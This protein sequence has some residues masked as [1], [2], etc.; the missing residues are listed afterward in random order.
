ME[1]ST[2]LK[3][4]KIDQLISDCIKN[5]NE[6]KSTRVGLFEEMIKLGFIS[7]DDAIPIIVKE[8]RETVDLGLIVI[9]MKYEVDKN[10]Y[11]NVP[12]LGP[13]HIL[14]YAYQQHYSMNKHLFE[15]FYILTV[16][17]GTST[18]S[19]SYHVVQ[20]QNPLEF[21]TGIKE[22]HIQ[23]ESVYEWLANKGCKIPSIASE[24][25]EYVKLLPKYDQNVINVYTNSGNE[26]PPEM[27]VYML[28]SRNPYWKKLKL[29]ELKPNYLK[30]AVNS[31][32]F[33]LV[34]NML[35]TGLRP[36]YIDFSFWIAHYKYISNFHN[37]NYLIE[38]CELMI[39][40]LI[41][42][43][44]K[45]DLYYLDEIGSINPRFRTQLI[46]EYQRP[47]FKKV[48]SNNEDGYIPDEIKTVAVY[49]GIS[50]S[51]KANFCSSIE[52]ITSADLDSLIGA[53]QKKNNEAMISKVNSLADYINSTHFKG[54]TNRGDFSDNPLNYPIDLLA[55]YKDMEG[56][57]WCFLSKDF[58]SL[59][60]KKINPTTKLSLPED[61]II[62]LDVQTKTLKFFGINL[63]DP[64]TISKIIAEIKKDDSPS[65]SSSDIVIE[66]V[67]GLLNSKGLTEHVLIYD[68]PLRDI[69]NRFKRL[70]VDF[71]DIILL[72]D[73]EIDKT[74]DQANTE[75]SPK[76]I[77]NLLC[78]CLD[79]EL[80][81]DFNQL[82]AFFT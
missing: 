65:N 70:G 29:E 42:R 82:T 24:L 3:L 46:E 45:I 47:L 55:Y 60:H 33:E 17:L 59:L 9:C 66:R 35:N 54:C 50:D 39:I 57:T 13:A 19:P 32:F 37:N 74:I 43:G 11:V 79:A 48:C 71:Q 22:K 23:V 78:F 25:I 10:I 7:P 15:M 8:M 56:K 73:S 5:E 4:P 52:N 76:V 51:N 68:I 20:K 62:R 1:S 41:R 63:S 49:L 69:I 16:L 44:F 67:K 77:Y 40:D 38:Q 27:F 26:W 18:L 28:A 53:N 36:S 31:T 14:L 30:A 6:L 72:S 64:K 34:A 2:H 61:F 80:L 81:K 12:G 75:F 21:Y 58:E